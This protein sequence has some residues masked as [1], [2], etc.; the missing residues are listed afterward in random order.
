VVS[1]NVV[2]VATEAFASF[3]IDAEGNLWA[4]G[5]DSNDELGAGTGFEQ[6]SPVAVTGMS[7]ANLASGP[8]AVQTLAVGL[9]LPP[10]ITVQPTNQTVSA[11]SEVTLTVGATG[12]APLAYQWQLAG[13]PID[14]ATASSYS[15]NPAMAA[16]AGNYTVVVTNLCG[17]VTSAMATLTVNPVV[18]QPA[19]PIGLL[20]LDG[21]TYVGFQATVGGAYVICA[22]T[23]LA[24]PD[25]WSVMSTN[26][27]SPDGVLIYSEPTAWP[28]RFF[29]AAA[30][31]TTLDQTL[32]K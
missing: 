30:A 14:G 27:A 24:A 28:Q 11:G 6:L 5:D 13:N 9:P 4:T 17:S 10:A 22:S 32:K 29:R 12:F 25:S 18:A 1:S 15:L 19:V 26:V 8:V 7:L 2:A 16:N 31:P 23:N 3:F 21:I 20:N